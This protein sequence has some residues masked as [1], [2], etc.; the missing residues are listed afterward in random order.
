MRF[1]WSLFSKLR[2]SEAD[3]SEQESRPSPERT[4]YGGP[5]RRSGSD[6]RQ[7]V[8]GQSPVGLRRSLSGLGRRKSD[9]KRSSSG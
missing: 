6:R 8:P 7:P 5:E 3:S 4:A 1:P 2:R 9:R